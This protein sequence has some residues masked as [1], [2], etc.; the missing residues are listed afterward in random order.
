MIV[1]NLFNEKASNAIANLA[2]FIFFL[3]SFVHYQLQNCWFIIG[4][5]CILA[6]TTF[7]FL[8]EMKSR[9][10]IYFHYGILDRENALTGITGPGIL[11]FLNMN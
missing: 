9:K 7:L 11:L 4:A 8:N 2:L 6:L 10:L 5:L 1:K 3:I